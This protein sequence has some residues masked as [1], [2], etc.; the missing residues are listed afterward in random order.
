MG[1]NI[2][3]LGQLEAQLF[4]SLGVVGVHDVS[5]IVE[6]K[7]LSPSSSSVAPI[8]ATAAFITVASIAPGDSVYLRSASTLANRA[9]PTGGNAMI[10][11]NFEMRVTSP[12]LP[13]LL[14]WVAFLDFG[15]VWQRGSSTQ[16]LQF[17][18][19]AL[20]PGIGVRIRT[21]IGYLRADVAYNDYR[22]PAGAAY[23]D[24]PL[25]EGGLLYCVSPGNTLAAARNAQ[26]V[27]EQ[28]TGTCPSTFRPARPSS[29]LN[30]LTTQFAIGQAF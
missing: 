8:A 28:R 18:T 5:A 2:V 25:T 19:L 13:A 20:T 7:L 22:R 29:F 9:V 16:R 24:A 17:K 11:G 12:F 10:L 6:A 3:D 4:Q 27:L 14:K 23:F 15:R 21:P 1:A 26:G 30:R